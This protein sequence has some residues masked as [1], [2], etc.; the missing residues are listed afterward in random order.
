[1]PERIPADRLGAVPHLVAKEGLAMLLSLVAIGLLAALGDAP[2]DGPADPE[3][4]PPEFVKAPWI[5]VGIQV[6]L[7]DLP[8]VLGGIVLPLAALS[9]VALI[10]WFPQRTLLARIA[11]TATFLGLCV[12][13]GALTLWGLWR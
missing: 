13:A 7:R 5:F 11:G 10:P 6:M 9:L 12:G 1:M 3:G 4:I 2:T 8:A